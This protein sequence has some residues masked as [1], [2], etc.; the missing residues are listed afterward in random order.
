MRR[1]LLSV[2]AVA[3][4][5]L[6]HTHVAAAEPTWRLEQPAPPSGAPFQ[7]P[8]GAPGDLDFWAPDRG[9][10]SVEGNDTVPRGLFFY[11]GV[12]WTQLTTVCGGSGDTS[13]IAW[14][15]PTEFWVVTEPSRPR[16][17]DGLGLCHFKDG[18]IVGSYSTADGVADPYRQM[19]SAACSRPD[20]CW[21]G[22]IG[23]RD[24]TGQR[25]G[26][27]LL[28]WN[29]VALSSSYDPQGRGISDLQWTGDRFLTTRFAGSGRASR[30][31][32]DLADPEEDGPRLLRRI[33]PDAPTSEPLVV[34]DADGVARQDT[35][36]LAID[37]AGDATWVVGGGA[38]S[39]PAAPD[40]GQAPRPPFAAR[41]TPDGWREWTADPATYGADESFTDVAVKPGTQEALVAASS[42]ADRN[43]TTVQARV[44]TLRP[45]GS[46]ELVVLPG[47]TAGR[48]AAARVAC[49]A[50]D[51]CWM[52]TSAGWLFHL[53]D[54]TPRPRTTDPAFAERI[55]QRPNESAEQYVPDAP[56]VDD[57][58]L[59]A[60]PPVEAQQPVAPP[61]A[62]V[63]Q[64]PPLMSKVRSRVTRKLVL[65]I[66]FR[67]NRSSRVGLV[68][69]RGGRVVGRVKVRRLQRG[70]RTLRLQ[71]SRRRYPTK[72]RFVT[73]D[74][75]PAAAEPSPDD[76]VTTG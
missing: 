30:G 54:G 4:A 68:A 37:H 17:G 12:S 2:L 22:G 10:L 6:G 69:S 28:H 43:Q 16:A 5:T 24:G 72:L 59:F 34:R 9:L 40:D 11:D 7:V 3:A 53:T 56:P 15:G 14:A 33:G 21:F 25:V 41:L 19:S 65:V 63:K 71:L 13:R 75:R 23:T 66:S 60:P 55:D 76:T 29:G 57:S 35:E 1:R 64:R 31:A 48:G 39:G 32:P 52:V 51:E 73:P 67:M 70:T 47:G 18:A 45:D 26:A 74:E 8:L 38:G 44:A 62:V 36:L 61:A 27:F 49:P 50:V 58:Q 46:S 20:D 42:L